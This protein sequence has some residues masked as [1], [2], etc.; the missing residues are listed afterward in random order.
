M[1]DAPHLLDMTSAVDDEEELGSYAPK[2]QLRA[3]GALA[4]SDYERVAIRMADGFTFHEAWDAIGKKHSGG[5]QRKYRNQLL[6]Q[7]V[8]NGRVE[9]IVSERDA[10]LA[11]D[12]LFGETKHVVMQ[13]YREAFAQSDLPRIQKAVE[14]RLEIAKQIAAR[15]GSPAP[16]VTPASS[17]EPEETRPVGRPAVED[18][19]AKRTMDDMRASLAARG[20]KTPMPMVKVQ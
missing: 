11:E 2:A 13:L 5:N 7:K 14:M 8:F 10:A 12:D 19:Q 16:T 9:K 4:N 15:R 18:P 1:R 17:D 3:D 6:K 20:V